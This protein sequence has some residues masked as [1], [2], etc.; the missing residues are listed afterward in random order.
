M[1]AAYNHGE[2]VPEKS[3][4]YPKSVFFIISNEFCE[5][6]SFFG[7]RKILSLYLRNAL[8][9]R[10]S[11]AVSIYHGFMF[12]NFAFPILGGILADSYIGK[13]QTI[14]YSSIVHTVG[15]LTVALAS[16]PWISSSR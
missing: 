14:A 4:K 16:T 5:R 13:Y 7:L 3:L 1:T 8:H 2:K 11:E 6:Y 9:F 12:F 15:N 10:E